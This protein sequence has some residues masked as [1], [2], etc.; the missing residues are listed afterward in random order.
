MNLQ[1][2]TG[3]SNHLTHP[4]LVAYAVFACIWKPAGYTWRVLIKAP[5]EPLHIELAGSFQAVWMTESRC[6]Y[7][8]VCVCSAL[9]SSN[10]AWQAVGCITFGPALPL[11]HFHVFIC[12]CGIPL[13]HW[14]EDS[15]RSLLTGGWT[16]MSEEKFGSVPAGRDATILAGWSFFSISSNQNW[17]SDFFFL[18]KLVHITSKS[19]MIYPWTDAAFSAQSKWLQSLRHLE[20]QTSWLSWEARFC[21]AWVHGVKKKNNVLSSL[22]HPHPPSSH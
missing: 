1:T 8:M 20:L 9:W 10:A 5:T 2:K 19:H 7:F 11:K 12:V 14:Y 16:V 6:C 18:R 21:E 17:K 22:P 13:P 3:N 4:R 15:R